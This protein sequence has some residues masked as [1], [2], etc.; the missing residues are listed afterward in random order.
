M[1]E[2]EV[3]QVLCR[4]VQMIAPAPADTV[5]PDDRLIGDLGFHSLAMVELAFAI[6]DLFAIED[7]AIEQ[8][9]GS[10]A[11]GISCRL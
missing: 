4:V 3:S 5:K 10:S 9:A 1:D 2:Q 6:E 11:C 8:A 7:M